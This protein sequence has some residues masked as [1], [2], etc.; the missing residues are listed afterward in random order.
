MERGILKKGN[1]CEFIG[2][3]KVLKSTVTGVEMFHQ[4]LE[5]AQ[6][7]DQLGALVRGVKRDD[8]RRGMIMCKPGS[9]KAH[10]N[11]EAQV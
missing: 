1:D 4:I 5:E 8:I 9:C 7:G 10:D 3:N 6:A 2:Y 11:V